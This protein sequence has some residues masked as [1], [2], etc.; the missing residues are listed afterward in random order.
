MERAAVVDIG[1]NSIRL[2]IFDRRAHALLQ[3][4]NEK[5][6][7]GLGR[8]LN[9]SG[10]LNPEGV[11][12]A[13]ENLPRFAA[14]AAAMG[15]SDPVVFATAAVRDAAD[16]PEFLAAVRERAGFDVRLV[17]GDEEARLAALGVASGILEAD[18]VVGDLGGGSLELISL[19]GTT[20]GDHATLPLG[21]FRVMRDGDGQAAMATAID[22]ELDRLPWLKE[23][24]GRN[25]YPVGGTWRALA[26][27]HMGWVDY[28]LHVI[29]H[30]A[31]TGRTA[32]DMATLLS[33]FG[34]K[35]LSKIKG[36]PKRRQET[37]PYGSLVLSTV[38]GAAGAAAGD[39]LGLWRTRGHHLRGALRR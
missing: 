25:F 15:A 39:L 19:K 18:G 16:G 20:L 8:G 30:Y 9:K 6:M 31:I 33:R 24:R 23:L 1:S 17:S 36:A 21:V 3:V 13:L 2:V 29:H 5:V 22:R 4:F 12:A 14:V 34:R 26:R 37:L 10:R 28:P 32:A 27:I 11:A 7:C 38:A 35:S